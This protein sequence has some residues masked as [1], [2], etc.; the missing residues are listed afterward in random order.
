MMTVERVHGDEHLSGGLE[1]RRRVL[2][3]ASSLN[4][5]DVIKKVVASQQSTI[6]SGPDSS[7]SSPPSSQGAEEVDRDVLDYEDE[8]GLTA[9]HYAVKK[10]SLDVSSQAHSVPRTDCDEE[11][12]TGNRDIIVLS[13]S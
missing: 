4:R 6:V 9:L 12:P 3:H 10:S 2:R 8:D 13:L 11:V 5:A 7:S 1:E